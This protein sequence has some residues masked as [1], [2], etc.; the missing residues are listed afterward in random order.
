VDKMSKKVDA[1]LSCE[2]ANIELLNRSS[3]TFDFV[4]HPSKNEALNAIKI[5]KTQKLI[6]NLLSSCHENFVKSSISKK[7]VAFFSLNSWHEIKVKRGE[8]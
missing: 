4:K 7:Y 5:R 1:F 6:L 2:R 3:A 8:N